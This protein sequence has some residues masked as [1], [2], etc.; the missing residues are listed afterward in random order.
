MKYVIILS[1]IF[2]CSCANKKICSKQETAR[3]YKIYKKYDYTF[4]YGISDKD[5]LVFIM[6]S[7]INNNCISAPKEIKIKSLKQISYLLI[8]SDTL[9][10]QYS[11]RDINNTMNVQVGTNSPGL[12]KLPCLNTYNSYP[13]LIES[14]NTLINN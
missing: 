13:Y 1:L 11:V 12:N 6:D 2:T 14:C 3:I 5:T 4:F 9:C 8:N 10:F 7:K